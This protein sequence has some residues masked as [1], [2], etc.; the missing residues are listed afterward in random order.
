METGD[1]NRGRG[2]KKLNEPTGENKR[3]KMIQIENGGGLLNMC[4]E[5]HDLYERLYYCRRCGS[6][7]C[8]SCVD[9]VFLE[10]EEKLRLKSY[11]LP[12]PENYTKPW[13]C[14]DIGCDTKGIMRKRYAEWLSD[15]KKIA[16]TGYYERDYKKAKI[17]EA[18]KYVGCIC[19]KCNP[20][21]PYGTL[22]KCVK[23]DGKKISD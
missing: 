9:D 13:Y 7:L 14:N 4:W 5:C 11:V 15:E 16:P 8:G 17:E 6:R 18:M 3:I 1:G 22:F 20:S 21:N 10:K 19:A 2:N 23:E 12:R